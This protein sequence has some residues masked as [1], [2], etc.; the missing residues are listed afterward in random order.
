MS[1]VPLYGGPTL[2]ESVD[3]ACG[4]GRGTRGV[5][6]EQGTPVSY[7]RGTPVPL[8]VGISKQRRWTLLRNTYLWTLVLRTTF[9]RCR[10]EWC[11]VHLQGGP[12]LLESE[13]GAGGDW[14]GTRG[15]PAGW[16][17]TPRISRR[18]RWRLVRNTRRGA[19]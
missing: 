18:R 3:D 9:H 19:P 16:F 7:E 2:L 8:Q 14:F 12:T 5:S 10:G 17:H 6:C 4:H 1:E 15:T 11:S 13:D